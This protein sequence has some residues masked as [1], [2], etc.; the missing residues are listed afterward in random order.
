MAG[1]AVSAVLGHAPPARAEGPGKRIRKAVGW[2]M[3][4]GK[5]SA[6]DK[7]RLVKDAGFEGVEVPARLPKRDGVL[8]F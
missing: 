5:L 7:L 6:E 2:N 8:K 1:G 3:I 4:Q